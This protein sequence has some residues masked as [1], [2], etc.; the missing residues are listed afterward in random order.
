MIFPVNRGAICRQQVNLFRHSAPSGNRRL[1]GHLAPAQGCGRH[2]PSLEHFHNNNAPDSWRG[3]NSTPASKTIIE[4]FSPCANHVSQ[5]R[6]RRFY[7][8]NF[9][10]RKRLRGFYLRPVQTFRAFLTPFHL[11]ALGNSIML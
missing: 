3:N 8:F 11:Y 2:L 4:P 5:R 9:I 6:P 10:T 7:H 1:R